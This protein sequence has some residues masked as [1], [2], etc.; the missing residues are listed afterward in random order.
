MKPATVSLIKKELQ[1]RSE[2]QKEEIIL[3]LARFKKENKELLSYLLF[4]SEDEEDYVRSIKHEVDLQFAQIN[5]ASFYY[6]KKSLRKILRFIDRYLKYS[7]V[8]QSE[9]EL[10]IHYLHKIKESKINMYRSQAMVNLRNRQIQ[11]VKN[12]ISKMHEDEAFDYK[13]DIERLL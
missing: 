10:R 12:V 1:G 8:L 7:K 2:A 5:H 11:K 4:D 13:K 9:A 3:R 6:V